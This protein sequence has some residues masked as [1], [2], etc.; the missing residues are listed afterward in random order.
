MR[1]RIRVYQGFFQTPSKLILHY[2]I[3]FCERRK[4]MNKDLATEITA[5]VTDKNDKQVF[6]QKNGITYKVLSE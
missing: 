6:V 2:L 3:F 1:I 4:R 5:M